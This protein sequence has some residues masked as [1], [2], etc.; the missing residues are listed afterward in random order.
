MS[1]PLISLR[2]RAL[3][4]PRGIDSNIHA[5][6]RDNGLVFPLLA[7]HVHRISRTPQDRAAQQ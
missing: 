3:G 2:M 1:N 4:V 6:L 7:W 5:S